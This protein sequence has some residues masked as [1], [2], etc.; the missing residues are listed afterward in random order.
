[1]N[2]IYFGCTIRSNVK[3]FDVQVYKS[4][5]TET[6]EVFVREQ[7]NNFNCLHLQ[8]TRLCGSSCDCRQNLSRQVPVFWFSASTPRTTTRKAARR[9]AVE[10]AARCTPLVV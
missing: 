3:G 8:Y 10:T 1:M 9:T 6:V 5:E 7:F 4:R 2:N